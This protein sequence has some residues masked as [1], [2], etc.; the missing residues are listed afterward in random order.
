MRAH[1]GFRIAMH[2]ATP[3]ATL[4]FVSVA[5]VLTA[6]SALAVTPSDKYSAMPAST[7]LSW[8]ALSFKSTRDGADLTG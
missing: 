1:G 3:L 7:G 2:V 4:A 5:P 8:S 6:T